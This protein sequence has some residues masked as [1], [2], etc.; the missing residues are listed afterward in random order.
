[1]RWVFILSPCLRIKSRQVVLITARMNEI[2]DVFDQILTCPV[3]DLVRDV[4]SI[5]YNYFLCSETKVEH[6]NSESLILINY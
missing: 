1:M 5:Y 6:S 2:R 4:N 3:E